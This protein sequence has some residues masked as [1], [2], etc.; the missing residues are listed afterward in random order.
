MRAF[1]TRVVAAARTSTTVVPKCPCWHRSSGTLRHY[2]RQLQIRFKSTLR[3]AEQSKSSSSPSST[4]TTINGFS[5]N[6]PYH[7][8]FRSRLRS[9]LLKPRTVPVPRWISPRHITLTLS[10]LCG[11]SSFLLVAISY[12]VDDYLQL[13]ILAVAG[14]T[15]MLFFAYFHP[16]GQVLWLPLRWNMLFIAINSYRIGRK[17]TDNFFAERIPIE[18]KGIRDD[19][20]SVMDPPDFARLVRAGTIET[21]AVGDVLVDQVSFVCAVLCCALLCE[22]CCPLHKTF[23]NGVTH[24]VFFFLLTHSKGTMNPYVRLVIRG[25]LVVTR[26]GVQTYRLEEGNFL[27]E[28]GMHT[29]L[30]LPGKIESCCTITA[31]G[32]TKTLRWHRNDLTDL[33]ERDKGFRRALKAVLSW[34]I[35]RKLKA[36]RY[37]LASGAIKDPE[38]WTSKR[39]EQNNARYRAILQSVLQHPRQFQ[40]RKEELENYR[41]IHH[42]DDDHHQEALLACGWTKEEFESGRKE[43]FVYHVDDEDDPRHDLKWVL[44]DVYMRLFG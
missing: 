13:R 41:I 39:N 27:S 40:E 23:L 22:Q 9:F 2:H 36:Q 18:F 38:E 33:L 42:I 30:L 15:A 7:G 4:T 19:H 44:R 5:K 37:L 16:H 6:H 35:V 20:F 26:D 14:S 34:D 24:P 25:D 10:E 43:G 11:H 32:P 31:H 21:Y 17:L 12:A 28:S 3:N 29:G 1:P 8:V